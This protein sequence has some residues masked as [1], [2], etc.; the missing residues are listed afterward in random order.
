MTKTHIFNFIARMQAQRDREKEIHLAPFF[1]CK[2]SP[3]Q[4]LKTNFVR[5]PGQT[6]AVAVAPGAAAAAAA[7]GIEPPPGVGHA[8]DR[9]GRRGQVLPLLPSSSSLSPPE[10]RLLLQDLLPDGLEGQLKIKFD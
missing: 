4:K 7:V 9:G 2:A 3:A 5:A 10:R 6:V 1:L 8:Q